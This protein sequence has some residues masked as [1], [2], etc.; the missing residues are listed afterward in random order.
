MTIY[1]DTY[2]IRDVQRDINVLCEFKGFKKL[3]PQD[4]EQ[5]ADI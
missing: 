3:S 2:G 4:R 5:E 1:A